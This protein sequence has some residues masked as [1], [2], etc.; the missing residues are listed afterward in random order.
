MFQPEGNSLIRHFKKV[1]V[2]NIS[3]GRFTGDTY[4]VIDDGNARYPVEHLNAVQAKRVGVV[5]SN[6]DYAVGGLFQHLAI[7]YHNNFVV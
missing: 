1:A 2:D 5:L 6:V 3:H 7:G 4:L